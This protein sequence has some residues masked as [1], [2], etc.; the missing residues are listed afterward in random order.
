MKDGLPHHL[1]LFCSDSNVTVIRLIN[2]Y[3]WEQIMI[4]CYG[5]CINDKGHKNNKEVLY[6]KHQSSTNSI[7]PKHFQ[8]K[9]NGNLCVYV[10]VRAHVLL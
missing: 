5:N 1:V 10:C 2:L 6:H 7:F 4:C 3:P 9:K 8:W